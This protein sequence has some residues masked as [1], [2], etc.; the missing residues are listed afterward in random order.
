M[1]TLMITVFAFCM[2]ACAL[3]P[4]V[5]QPE[6]QRGLSQSDSFESSKV[7]HQSTA[8]GSSTAQ[9]ADPDTDARPVCCVTC[10]EVT[11]CG[12]GVEMSCGS[13]STDEHQSAPSAIST[14][15][16]TDPNIAQC[17]VTCGAVTACGGAV[18]MECGSCG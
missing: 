7:E 5:D 4:T 15:Q 10:G 11:A 2:S 9:K 13:C 8:S 1:K 12:S 6:Q 16:E 18:D 17:C 3:D 14:T